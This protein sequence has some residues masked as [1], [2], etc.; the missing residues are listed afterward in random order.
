M[1]ICIS[2]WLL[3]GTASA[4]TEL[5]GTLSLGL[6]YDSN[7]SVDELD[8]ASNVG[9]TGRLLNVDLGVEH[10]FSEATSASLSYSFAQVNYET[11]D[12]LSRQTHMLGADISTDWGAATT[13]INYFYINALL[14]GEDF[15]TYER[16]SPSV[17]GF[18]S[19]RWFLRG[20]YVHGEKRVT[21]RPGRN[22]RNDG[23]EIDAYYFWR[24]LRRYINAGYVYRLEDSQA[25]RFD[26]AAHQLKLRWVQRFELWS[27]LA[28]FELGARYEVRDYSSITPIIAE[29]R[30]DDRLRLKA[31]LDMPLGK[32]VNWLIYAGYS[33]YVSNLPAADYEQTLI[34]TRVEWS[35]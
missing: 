11:F 12:N 6:E 28:T 19:K 26:Y 15:L 13:G 34:G 35:F 17:S 21:R 23:V 33:D 31:E 30:D 7:V 27:E 20:A 22:A 9:D 16:V 2:V 5:S 14:D 3:A 4:Q 24:G 25:P 10:D 8:R 1:L 32:Q 29:E 18:V